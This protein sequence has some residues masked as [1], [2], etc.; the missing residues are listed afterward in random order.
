SVELEFTPM[1][2]HVTPDKLRE[3][4]K[5]RLADAGGAERIVLGFGLCG[6][7]LAGLRSPGVPLIVPKMHDCI[8]LF[9]GSTQTFEQVR[10]EEVG[11]LFLTGGWMEGERTY[12]AEYRQAIDKYGPEKGARLMSILFASYRRV[13]LIRTGHPKEATRR[14]EAAELAR[15]LS[16]ELHERDGHSGWLDALVNGPWDGERFLELPPFGEIRHEHY[17]A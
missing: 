13:L 9:L 14:R 12:L 6:G 15:L 10:A 1:G 3:E 2:L 4:L 16:L 7:A 8:P 11:T 17:A 5:T